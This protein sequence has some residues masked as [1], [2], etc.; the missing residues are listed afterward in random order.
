MLVDD[1]ADIGLFIESTLSYCVDLFLSHLLY[2]SVAV[3]PPLLLDL[4][5]DVDVVVTG[6]STAHVDHKGE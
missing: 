3:L 6:D 4:V 2:S 5:V 1:T